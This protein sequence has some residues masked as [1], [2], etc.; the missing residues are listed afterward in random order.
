M[1]KLDK[2]YQTY[3]EKRRTKKL[4]GGSVNSYTVILR[5]A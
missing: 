1:S 4:N 5:R 2:V 3:E